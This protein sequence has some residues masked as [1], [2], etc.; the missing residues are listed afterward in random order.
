VW[1]DVPCGAGRLSELLPG[2]VVQ[3]DRAR[4]MLGAAPAAGHRQVCA[5]A[6]A[7]PFRDDAFAGSL[8]HRL[9]HHVPR[10]AERVRILSELRRVTDGPV[11]VSFFHAVSVQNARRLLRRGL[12][13]RRSGRVAITLRR[14]RRELQAA[15]LRTRAA[16][17]LMPLWSEQWLIWAERA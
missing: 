11:L 14:F 5:S 9:L 16:V 17:P 15:G 6:G 10:S 8:C 4:E 12:R 13:S 7:L 1:L 2:T 3:V